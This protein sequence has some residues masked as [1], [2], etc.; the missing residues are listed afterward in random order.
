MFSVETR[1][2]HVPSLLLPQA[3]MNPCYKRQCQPRGREKVV[4]PAVLCLDYP[5]LQICS[6]S[7]LR[8]TPNQLSCRVSLVALAR[9]ISV[10]TNRTH[11]SIGEDNDARICAILLHYTLDSL[12]LSHCTKML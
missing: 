2:L 4:A 7:C 9:G 12:N 1:L 11:G 10:E 5:T 8:C 6:I 3:R